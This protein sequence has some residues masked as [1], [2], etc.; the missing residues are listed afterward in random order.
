MVD[1]KQR[2]NSIFKI[3]GQF[4]DISTPDS[5]V[6]EETYKN[7]LN[8]LSI[9]YLGYGNN[10]ILYYIE[11]LYKLGANADHDTVRR[12]VFHIIDILDKEV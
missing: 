10:D 6:T 4:E 2:I 5:D 9:W 12:T 8:R 3:L 1:K 7:Y 11:G